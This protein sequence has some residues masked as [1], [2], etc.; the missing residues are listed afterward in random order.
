MPEFKFDETMQVKRERIENI[1]YYGIIKDD[2]VW[3]GGANPGGEI[4][5]WS[6]DKVNEYYDRVITEEAIEKYEKLLNSGKLSERNKRVSEIKYKEN[7]PTAE[8]FGLKE[9][10]DKLV[11]MGLSMDEINVRMDEYNEELE[12]TQLCYERK[13]GKLTNTDPA[14]VVMDDKEKDKYVADVKSRYMRYIELHEKFE[15]KRCA[16]LMDTVKD[17]KEKLNSCKR[18][19]DSYKKI[20]KEPGQLAKWWNNIWSSITGRDISSVRRYNEYTKH[21]EISGDLEKKIRKTEREINKIRQYNDGVDNYVANKEENMLNL[22]KS[23]VTKVVNS[24]AK[25]QVQVADDV[26][27]KNAQMLMNTDEFKETVMELKVD[28]HSIN[29]ETFYNRY[30]H[31]IKPVEKV[32][33]SEKSTME[34][35]LVDMSAMKSDENSIGI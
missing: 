25:G 1:L 27:L 31:K 15:A 24:S 2:S 26:I 11:E 20:P 22:A 19:L 16:E 35:E 14:D 5:N 7:Y 10:R 18:I 21:K 3:S 29:P 6:N 12:Y 28:N 13:F 4:I 8:S 30:I 9:K 17:D 34:I 32:T 33:N 23:V